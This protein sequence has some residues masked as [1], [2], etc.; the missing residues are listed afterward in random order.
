MTHPLSAH[1]L[2]VTLLCPGLMAATPPPPSAKEAGTTITAAMR[3]NAVRN[4]ER[5]EWA[6]AQRDQLA[7]RLKPYLEADD[8]TLWALLPDQNVPRASNVDPAKTPPPGSDER[9]LTTPPVPSRGFGRKFHYHIDPFRHPWKIQSRGTKEWYP[10]NDFAAYHASALDAQGRFQPG[11][12]DPRFLKSDG[13]EGT[14]TWV[15]DGTGALVDGQRHFFVAHYAFRI[16]SELVD[17]VADLATLY[18]LTNDPAVAHK[19]GVLLDRMADLYP[20]MDYNPSYRLGMEAS[21]GGSGKGRVQGKIWESFNAQ[22]L[23]LA[24]D[25]VFDALIQDAALEE[26]SANMA[27]KHGLEPKGGGRQIAAHIEENLIREFIRG[28]ADGRIGG[29]PGMHQYSVAAAAIALDNGAE[30]RQWLDWLFLPDGGRLP[31]ILVD[32]MTRDGFG[33]EGGLGYAS[34]PP[35]SIFAVAELLAAY[36][37]YPRRDL[38]SAFPKFRNA[39]AGGERLRILEGAGLQCGDGGRALRVGDYGYPSPMPMALAGFERYGT[40]ENA[41]EL[42]QAAHGK[43]ENIPGDP[44]AADPEAARQRAIAAAREAGKP[45]PYKSFNS[46]GIGFGVLQAPDREAP[47]MVALNYGPMGWG[48]GHA[49]RLGLHLIANNEYLAGDLGYP[50]RTG[51]YPPRLGWTSHTV[52]HNTVM[53]DDRALERDSSL[54]GKT[55]LFAEAGP[56]RVIDIDGGGPATLRGTGHSRAQSRPARLHPQVSTYRRCV[57]MVDID[58]TASYVVDLFWVRGGSTHRLIQNGASTTTQSNHPGWEKQAGGSGAG[59]NVPYGHFYDGKPT[60]G[61]NGSGLMYLREIERAKP[62]G[63]FWVEWALGS[64]QRFRVHAL[65]P[66]AE[67]MQGNGELPTPGDGDIRYLHRVVRGEALETQFVTVLEAYT[68]K[69]QLAECRILATAPEGEPFGVAL[70]IRLADGRVDRLVITEKEGTFRAGPLELEGRVGWLRTRADGST[71]AAA[72]PD[73]TLLKWEDQSFKAPAATTGKLTELDL[74]DPGNVIVSTSLE[75]LPDEVV[76]RTLIVDNHQ[77][78]D[79][80]YRIHGVLPGGRLNLGPAALEERLVDPEDETRGRIPNIAPGESFRIAAPRFIPGEPAP[81]AN[82]PD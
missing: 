70:E 63:S 81:S 56:V 51:P 80:S 59:P 3:R 72:L 6:A 36:P 57:A 17:V 82:E 12:G 18:T 61:Y 78:A 55:Q 16:W 29:N 9:H 43:P 41:R 5:Y 33:H 27:R 31:Q 14:E 79:A 47:R 28:I 71:E 73:A 1:L 34:I 76:G 32:G 49:D 13:P 45:K 64:G 10:K 44:Y 2:C 11:K 54:S 22:K 50:T 48:H 25:R 24:Y 8:A 66:K 75:S 19:A 26:F 58:P 62:P 65:A 46:G 30:T 74:T 77:R 4:T 35:R 15:D 21:T 68:G 53:V 52:S 20:A 40:P 37:G 23:S 42:Y 60:W 7:K 39:L 67:A 38:F 69:P